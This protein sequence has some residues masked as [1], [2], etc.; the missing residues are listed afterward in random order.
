MFERLLARVAAALAKHKIPYMV[1]GGQAVLLYGE[2]RATKD[3]DITLAL[4]I[5]KL[6]RV[7]DAI[8]AAKLRLLADDA[9]AF[10]RRTMVVP[11]R[12]EKTG[13]RVDFILSFSDFERQAVARARGVKIGRTTVRFASLEDLVIHKMIAGRPRDLEDV[14]TIL[15]KNPGFDAAYVRYWLKAFDRSLDLDTVAGFE[16]LLKGI[17]PSR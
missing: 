17:R 15:L 13:I 9:E 3:I 11:A 14:E 2:P 8:R 1:I 7:L 6:G 5:D 16:A 4:G 12:N 10:A